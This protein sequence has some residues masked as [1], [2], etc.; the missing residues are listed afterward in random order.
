MKRKLISVL[1]LTAVIAV[2]AQEK[3]FLS[4]IYDYLE[5]TQVFE[6]NQVEG[7]VPLVPYLTVDEALKNNRSGATSFLSLNG[8]WKFHFANTPEKHLINSLLKISTIKNG[9][10]FMCHPAGRCRDSAIHFSG[11]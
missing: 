9:I 5:N 7:H 8:T 10:L 2:A 3:S 4:N 1:F 11:T 6:V